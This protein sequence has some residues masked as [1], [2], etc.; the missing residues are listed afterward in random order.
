V[1]APPVATTL[2]SR[3]L[4]QPDLIEPALAIHAANILAQA[5]PAT[6]GNGAG[7]VVLW[8]AVIIVIILVGGLVVFQ[9]RKRLLEN[10]GGGS[11][12]PFGLQELR[13]LKKTGQISEQEY[14]S[15]RAK[16]IDQVK[17]ALSDDNAAGEPAAPPKATARPRRKSSRSDGFDQ[18]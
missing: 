9:L 10:E 17:G 2:T 6:T 12:D 5:P 15:L 16:V 1:P 3:P 13:D 8:G 18:H 14:Q 11:D 4:T 7:A